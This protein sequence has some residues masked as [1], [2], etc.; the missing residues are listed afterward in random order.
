M[1][2]VA[3]RTRLMQLNSLLRIHA[4]VKVCEF[5]TNEDNNFILQSPIAYN[6]HDKDDEPFTKEID[7]RNQTGTSTANIT[8]RKYDKIL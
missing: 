8:Q 6:V 2:T 1:P 5:Q 3:K 4:P 7:F